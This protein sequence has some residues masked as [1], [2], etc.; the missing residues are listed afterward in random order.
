MHPKTLLFSALA[1]ALFA[2]AGV[3]LAQSDPNAADAPPAA[4]SAGA[5]PA[6]AIMVPVGK[7]DTPVASLNLM[8][9]QVESLKIVGADDG[10]IGEVSKVL[11]DANGSPTAVIVEVGGFL[12]LG[13]KL[14][15]FPLTNLSLENG[16]LRTQMT[17]DQIEKLPGYSG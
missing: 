11:G 3:G 10:E 4:T 5:A 7:A 9:S 14:L 8:V 2:S 12:G 13:E 1:L 15:I 17:K 16:R 6:G